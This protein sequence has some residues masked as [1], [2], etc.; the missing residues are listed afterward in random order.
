M[1]AQARRVSASELN[2]EMGVP[3][4]AGSTDSFDVQVGGSHVSAFG[5]AFFMGRESLGAKATMSS[6][7]PTASY[8]PGPGSGGA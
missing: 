8:G 4:L 3:A 2:A 1:V 6:R 7:K 5:E